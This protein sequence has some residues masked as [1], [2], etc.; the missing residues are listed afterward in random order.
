[1]SK[2]N[3]HTNCFQ[4]NE[5]P[6]FLNGRERENTLHI[7]VKHRVREPL[8][9]KRRLSEVISGR[10]TPRTTQTSRTSRS[11]SSESASVRPRALPIFNIKH[12]QDD[13]K[14]SAQKLGSTP[15]HNS[16]TSSSLDDDDGGWRRTRSCKETSPRRHGGDMLTSSLN[17]R[18]FRRT[19]DDANALAKHRRASDSSDTSLNVL[20]QQRVKKTRS[21][22]KNGGTPVR[23][24]RGNS[25]LHLHLENDDESDGDESD[26]ESSVV[27]RNK[28]TVPSSD[29]RYRHC[30]S[31]SLGSRRRLVYNF[32]YNGVIRNVRLCLMFELCL[33]SLNGNVVYS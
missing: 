32:N 20:P 11:D 1:M 8:K 28:L 2:S 9:T 26:D 10:L 25:E 23:H 19:R 5:Y 21:S 24:Q 31:N 29:H 15:R 18:A 14:K 13:V 27:D 6:E 12:V 16:S 30:S 4:L 17:E 3:T 33:C 7:V 22:D